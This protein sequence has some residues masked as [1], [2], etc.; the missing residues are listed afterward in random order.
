MDDA[1]GQVTDMIAAAAIALGI[2]SF[3]VTVIA[4]VNGWNNV[5]INQINNKASSSY[6]LAYIRGDNLVTAAEAYT[7]IITENDDVEIQINGSTVSTTLLLNARN[8]NAGSIQNLRSMLQN[9]YKKILYY[10]DT[11]D[12][13]KINYSTP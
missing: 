1:T 2:I 9:E 11:G 4:S 8:N 5:L 3:C 13:T 12:I 10:N 7:D 6:S